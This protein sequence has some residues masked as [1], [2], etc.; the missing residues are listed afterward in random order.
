MSEG[1]L[2]YAICVI[3]CA[4]SKFYRV[5]DLSFRFEVVDGL[6]DFDNVNGVVDNVDNVFEGFVSLGA[7]VEGAFAD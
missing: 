3:E 6:H 4:Q 5:Q 7:F 2:S 1:V